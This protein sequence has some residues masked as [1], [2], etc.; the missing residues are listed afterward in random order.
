MKKF[1]EAATALL[2]FSCSLFVTKHFGFDTQ[3][4]IIISY[5]TFLLGCAVG[6]IN[7]QAD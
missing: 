2:F 4:R 1:V 6:K 5:A 3:D 7:T